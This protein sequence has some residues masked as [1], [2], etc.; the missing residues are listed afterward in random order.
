MAIVSTHALNPARRSRPVSVRRSH[1][2]S[3][4]KSANSHDARLS[5]ERGCRPCRATILSQTGP[6][7]AIHL[8]SLLW[9]GTPQ[10]IPHHS[11]SKGQTSHQRP[12]SPLVTLHAAFVPL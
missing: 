1:S 6:L 8:A 5:R 12:L 2:F 3:N 11:A 4:T 7:S 10:R 9:R